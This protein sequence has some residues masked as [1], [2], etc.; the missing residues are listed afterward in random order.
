MATIL[1]LAVFAPLFLL[2]GCASSRNQVITERPPESVM[3]FTPTPVESNI[4]ADLVLP[5]S[6]LQSFVE[7]VP[8]TLTLNDGITFTYNELTQTAESMA[9]PE[10][11]GDFLVR[12]FSSLFRFY[13]TLFPS[14]RPGDLK[15]HWSL[16]VSQRDFQVYPLPDKRRICFDELVALKRHVQYQGP[17]KFKLLKDGEIEGL[18]RLRT[19][20]GLGVDPSGNPALTITHDPQWLEGPLVGTWNGEKVNMGMLANKIMPGMF[21]VGD[22]FCEEGFSKLSQWMLSKYWK[23]YEFPLEM[24]GKEKLFADI[25]PLHLGLSGTRVEGKGSRKDLHFVVGISARTSVDSKPAG[26]SQPAFPKV[27]RIAVEPGKVNFFLPIHID[28][29]KIVTVIRGAVVNQS[30]A[31]QNEEIK[32]LDVCLYPSQKNLVVGVKLAANFRHEWWDLFGLFNVTG[33]MYME[34]IPT[35]DPQTDEFYLDQVRLTQSMDNPLWVFAAG[36]VYKEMIQEVADSSRINLKSELDGMSQALSQT[37]GDLTRDELVPI[38][39]KNSKLSVNIIP[40]KDLLL[41]VGYVA[42]LST[43]VDLNHLWAPLKIDCKGGVEP[44]QGRISA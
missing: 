42:R 27:S 11:F 34:G 20:V 4:T 18:M 13:Y 25:K 40:L 26:F 16:T 44:V 36:T 35:I 23:T 9:P 2:L 12:G 43:K 7:A 21:A 3:A 41:E 15:I 1:R 17:L 6:G 33:W 10:S 32:V 39:L 24:A 30:R 19:D 29:Q 38:T 8:N 37:V 14:L 5:L 28:Y 22:R 31:A